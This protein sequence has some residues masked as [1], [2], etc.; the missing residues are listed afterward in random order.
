[1]K[2]VEERLVGR[3]RN[4]QGVEGGRWRVTSKRDE[5]EVLLYLNLSVYPVVCEA[6]FFALHR[7]SE[8]SL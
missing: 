2:E 6:R 7:D 5:R 8:C 3:D 4:F 1:M